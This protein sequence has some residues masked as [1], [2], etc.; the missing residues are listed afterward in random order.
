MRWLIIC[1]LLWIVTAQAEIYKWV[2]ERGNVHFG[3]APPEHVKTETVTPNTERQGVRL[4]EPAAADAW[5]QTV[6]TPPVP[7]VSASDPRAIPSTRPPAA[8]DYQETDACEGVVGDCF[9]PA[10]DYV[11]KL[12]YGT[13]CQSVYHWKVCLQQTCEDNRLADKCESPFYFMNHRPVMLGQR[14]LQRP[15]PIREWVSPQDWECLSGSGFF[16]DELAFE[17]QCQQQ[18]HQSCTEL[19]NWIS[20]A[21]QRCIKQ[22]DGDCDDIDTLIRYRPAPVEEVKKAGIRNAA[23]GVVSQDLLLQQ[24]GVHKA[25]PAADVTLQPVLESI[26]GLNIRERRYRYDCERRWLPGR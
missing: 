11:C 17:H 20:S 26:T 1:S 16:C 21:R 13:D 23:G 15:L 14:D 2:D 8:V 9:T 25:E 7:E 10:Q 3:D 18:Y 24:L 12:R 19:K 6:L 22:R 4:T 5:K